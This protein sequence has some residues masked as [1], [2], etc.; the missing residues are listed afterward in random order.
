MKTL[1]AIILCGLLAA[2]PVLAQTGSPP[3]GSKG[4]N[5][6]TVLEC[7]I[8]LTIVAAAGVA[9]IY[10][11]SAACNSCTNKRLI[12]ECSEC[13]GE[14]KPIHTNDVTGLC[15]NKWEIFRHYTTD[16]AMRY[17]IKIEAIPPHY[18]P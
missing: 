12:L 17:R 8:M 6:F 13:S 2:E 1:L 4:T 7:A 16:P 3:P 11:Q 9:I 5:D 15:T 14:W 10:I 18:V